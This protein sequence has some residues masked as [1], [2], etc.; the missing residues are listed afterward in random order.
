M[1]YDILLGASWA[2]VVLALVFVI[3]EDVVDG[4]RIKER[5]IIQKDNK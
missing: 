4:F 5:G 3:S 1:N 2:F